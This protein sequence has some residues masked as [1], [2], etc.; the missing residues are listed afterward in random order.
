MPSRLSEG[1]MHA[2]S[3]LILLRQI[4]RHR[5]VRRLILTF[6]VSLGLG[7]SGPITAEGMAGIEAA[8]E[9]FQE[10]EGRARTKRVRRHT[11]ATGPRLSAGAPSVQASRPVRPERFARP[12]PGRRVRKIPSVVSDSSAESPDH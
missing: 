8:G 1:A 9:E 2:L 12:E 7:V 11:S 6:I 5:S 3:E 10:A 4:R